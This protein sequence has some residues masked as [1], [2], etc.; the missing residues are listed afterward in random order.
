MADDMTDAL[1]DM[2]L[3]RGLKLVR[4]RRRKPG[5]GD[6]GKFGL[7]DD[8]GKELL[9]FGADGLTASADEIENFLRAGATSTWQQ[10][11][12]ITPD[13]KNRTSDKKARPHEERSEAPESLSKRGKAKQ[14]S[15]PPAPVQ[16]RSNKARRATDKAS[17]SRARSMSASRPGPAPRP[18]PPAP[19]AHPELKIRSIKPADADAVGLLLNQLADVTMTKAE[20]ARAVAQVRKAGGEVAVAEL[21]AV[22]GC[23][24]WAI[25]PTLHRGLIGRISLLVVD[26]RHRR[27][28]IGTRLLEAAETALW[29]KCGLIEAMSDIDLKNSHGFFR[30]KGFEQKS[31]RFVRSAPR[32]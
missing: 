2:A 30:G 7:T 22:I 29:K 15:Q 17:A 4:S 14:E 11:A 8:T 6:F 32:A 10:S 25:V 3:H 27:R 19:A 31:Y 24:G 18:L 1:R 12:K 26:G 28:G 20:L 5:T 16:I 21:E 9:G 23:I 13:R